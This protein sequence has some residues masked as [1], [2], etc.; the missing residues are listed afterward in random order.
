MDEVK[1][2]S[3]ATL[4]YLGLMAS[5]CNSISIYLLSKEAGVPS[6]L[7]LRKRLL[8][9]LLW[10]TTT[11]RARYGAFSVPTAIIE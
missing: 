1:G 8:G 7:G 9:P 10:I 2:I 5:L 6:V 3:D 11:R 4:I